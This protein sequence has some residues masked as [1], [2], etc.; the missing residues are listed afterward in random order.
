MTGFWLS[1]IR[2]T[3]VLLKGKSYGNYNFQEENFLSSKILLVSARILFGHTQIHV[4]GVPYRKIMY[5]VQP[6][7]DI[8]DG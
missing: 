2:L 5:V 3:V 7:W 4:I 6:I 8:S 1:N